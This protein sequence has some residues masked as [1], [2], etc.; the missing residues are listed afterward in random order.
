M[1]NREEGKL[2]HL[3]TM[4]NIIFYQPASASN[5]QPPRW[6]G[7]LTA[8]IV[9]GGS[10]ASTSVRQTALQLDKPNEI[11]KDHMIEHRDL[12]DPFQNR[13][14]SDQRCRNDT[15]QEQGTCQDCYHNN[16][17]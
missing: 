4:D 1:A 2:L 15:V 6:P 7:A 17:V 11:W 13:H 3:P 9:S 5:S 14:S 8:S 10:V 16:Y 12:S